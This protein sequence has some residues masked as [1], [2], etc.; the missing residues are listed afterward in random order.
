MNK[1]E[2]NYTE[3]KFKIQKKCLFPILKYFPSYL[4]RILGSLVQY[5]EFH[6]GRSFSHSHDSYDIAQ[7]TTKRY[8]QL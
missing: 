3:I 4:F 6:H 1:S 2:T 8:C 7:S 5:Y